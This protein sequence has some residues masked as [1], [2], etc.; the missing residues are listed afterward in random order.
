MQQERIKTGGDR[1]NLRLV[2]EVW[3]G[4][5]QR[6]VRAGMAGLLTMALTALVM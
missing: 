5:L 6:R 4:D 1:K 3:P 2:P